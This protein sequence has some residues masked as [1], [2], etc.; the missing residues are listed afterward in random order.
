MN[1]NIK[2]KIFLFFFILSICKHNTIAYAGGVGPYGDINSQTIMLP[3]IYKPWE[4]KKSISI[5]FTRLPLDWV[6]TS[7]EVPIIQFNGKLG[8]PAGFTIESSLQSIYV[9]N[10][11]RIGPHWNIEWGKFSFAAGMDA[12]LLFG[13]M[14]IAGFDNKAWGWCNYPNL[15]VGFNTGEIAFTLS[16]EYSILQSLKITSGTTE[17]S[18]SKNIK[19]G[20][21]ISL[22]MEQRLWK[23]HVMIIG[24]INNFQK[25]YYISWPAFSTFNRRYYIPQ[26]YLG[27]VL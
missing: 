8:L 22:F 14:E 15:S 25:F 10:Q 12:A 20:Q 2:W 6:E 27:L 11:F 19:S 26:F 13:K 17:I 9:S 24:V 23:N 7:I 18:Q 5:L 4:F 3:H 21:S 1:Q 16:A